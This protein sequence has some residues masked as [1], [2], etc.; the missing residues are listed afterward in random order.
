MKVLVRVS[1]WRWE[2]KDLY[3]MLGYFASRRIVAK[4][5]QRTDGKFAVYREMESDM[6]ERLGWLGDTSYH[7]SNTS[8]AD[9]VASG[10]W[11]SNEIGRGVR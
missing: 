7:K 5:E 1:D 11:R 3:W 10:N 4:M 2:S 8:R 6:A 9:Q